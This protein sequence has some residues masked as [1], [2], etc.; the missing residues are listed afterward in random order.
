L[1]KL[2]INGLFA[3]NLVQKDCFFLRLQ[4]EMKRENVRERENMRENQRESGLYIEKNPKKALT[5]HRS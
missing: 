3:H 1:V 2:T 4:N 5:T